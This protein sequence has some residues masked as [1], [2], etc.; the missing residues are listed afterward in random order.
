MAFNAKV[1]QE[2]LAALPAGVA[3]VAVS[4]TKP[5]QDLQDA[6]AE[7]VRDFGENYVQEL[8]EK[9]PV[10]L[11]DIRWHFIGHLQSNKV[12]YIA[13]Y[14]HLI[15]GVDKVSL[16]DEIQKQA[17]KLGKK[18]AVLIQL[19]VAQ[20]ETKFG[21]SSGEAIELFSAAMPE[22]YPNIVFSGIM[23]MASFLDDTEVL[24]SEFGEAKRIF[25]HLAPIMGSE[26]NTLSMGMSSDW[27]LAV[28]EGSTLLRIGS[29]LFGS[30]N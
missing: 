27:Q 13:P 19:H 8:M 6:Y 21:F 1:Y 26:W 22:K 17:A 18:I 9:Q 14:V 5:I 11:A 4:K 25:D 7:G 23:A 16:L 10:L 2:I 12:K 30:R 15:H 29:T 24:K 20:E 28:Q 3:I